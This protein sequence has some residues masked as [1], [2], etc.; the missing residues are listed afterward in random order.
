MLIES[1][2]KYQQKSL[3]CSRS[4]YGY[5]NKS[6]NS[7]AQAESSEAAIKHAVPSGNNLD[8]IRKLFAK[9]IC[10]PSQAFSLDT[11]I[12]LSPNSRARLGV[13]KQSIWT[14]LPLVQSNGWKIVPAEGAGHQIFFFP[15]YVSNPRSFQRE[16]RCWKTDFTHWSF[17]ESVSWCK[18]S[19]MTMKQ[20]KFSPMT[21]KQLQRQKSKVSQYALQQILWRSSQC[22]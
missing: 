18:F 16:T 3:G 19:P 14:A 15:T 4:L 11:M 8:L 13:G 10:C 20:L 17:R 1:R 7:R 2:K 22:F 6:P 9:E 5:R 12:D 21:M